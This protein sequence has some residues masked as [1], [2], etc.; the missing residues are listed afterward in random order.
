MST[1]TNGELVGRTWPDFFTGIFSVK[2]IGFAIF[3]VVAFVVFMRLSGTSINIGKLGSI[4]VTSSDVVEGVRVWR[5]DEP[6]RL[7]T[8][9]TKTIPHNLGALPDIVQVWSSPNLKGPWDLVH[10]I[11]V[12]GKRRFG[13]SVIDV[14]DVNLLLRTGDWNAVSTD[15]EQGQWREYDMRQDKYDKEKAWFRVSIVTGL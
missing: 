1:N 12:N 8:N 10:N 2:A 7:D 13:V 14:T 15:S 9:E 6:F 4:T 3:V 5:I 11:Y